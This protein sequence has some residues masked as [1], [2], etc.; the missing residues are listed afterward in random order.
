MSRTVTFG[1]A[2]ALAIVLMWSGIGLR[3][4]A[5]C[6]R[7]A[8]CVMDTLEENYQMM[9]SDKMNKAI[10][11]GQDNITAFDRF[12]NAEKI[13]LFGT[14]LSNILRGRVIVSC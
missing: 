4:A 3:S 12:R 8:G 14:D 1:A 13:R 7:T 9:R 5:A 2:I 10:S 6:N 11:A